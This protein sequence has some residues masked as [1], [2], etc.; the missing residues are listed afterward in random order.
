M[1]TLSTLKS[2]TLAIALAFGVT[3]I[4]AATLGADAVQDSVQDERFTLETEFKQ[5]DTD[6]NALLSQAEFSND[7][8]FTK[9]H[10]VKAD[11]DNNGT[12]NQEEFVSYKSDTQK[13]AAKRV[14][15]DTVITSKAKAQL[16]AEKDLKSLQI[17]VK[18]YNGA[19][20][21]S[22]FVDDEIS[23]SKAE[24]IVSRIEGVKSVKN[25]LVVKS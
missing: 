12:L 22:G 20:I 10:F 25:S 11:V 5:L 13:Q 3:S 7:K 18:T 24:T 1:K 2:T 4:Q 9:G 6:S 8:F 17:S 16:L 19:V 15:S 23:K 21:L 14:A